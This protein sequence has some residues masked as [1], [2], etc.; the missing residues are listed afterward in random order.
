MSPAEPNIKPSRTLWEYVR[1]ELRRAHARRPMSFYLLL[2][3]PVALLLGSGITSMTGNPRRFAFFLTLFFVFFLVILYRASMDF[4]DI[5]RRHFSENERLF[6][7][8]LGDA[9]FLG[10]IRKRPNPSRDE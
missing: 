2:A 6:G 5:A 3:I 1:E 7:S 9:E 10:R 4:I 8:T